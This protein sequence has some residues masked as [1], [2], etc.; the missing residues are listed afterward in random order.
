MVYLFTF[1][2]ACYGVKNRSVAESTDS[3][4][5]ETNSILVRLI[6]IFIDQRALFHTMIFVKIGSRNTL[7]TVVRAALASET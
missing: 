1:F 2:L 6:L 5:D 7:D 3:S 4:I